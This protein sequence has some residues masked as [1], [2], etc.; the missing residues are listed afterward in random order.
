MMKAGVVQSKNYVPNKTGLKI[1]LDNNTIDSKDFKLGAKNMIGNWNIGDNGLYNDELG[2]KVRGTPGKGGFIS[3]PESNVVFYIGT[4]SYA[5]MIKNIK[6]G[7]DY[8]PEA[9]IGIDGSAYFK[10]VYVNERSLAELPKFVSG[11]VVKTASDTSVHMFTLEKLKTM[12]GITSVGTN[13]ITAIFA[14][15]DGN[16]ADTH[17]DGATWVGTNLYAVFGAKRDGGI[18]INYTIIYNPILYQNG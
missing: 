14:N 9:W 12:F 16:A 15:G 7:L 8:Y 13:N 2:S 11:T 10:N 4:K 1:D 18:R 5:E 6:S 17:I 3:H